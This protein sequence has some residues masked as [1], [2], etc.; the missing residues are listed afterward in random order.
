MAGPLPVVTGHTSC[1][2]NRETGPYQL[3]AKHMLAYQMDRQGP[4]LASATSVYA[5]HDHGCVRQP[6]VGLPMVVAV[7]TLQ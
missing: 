1:L 6:A 3:G 4:Q 7:T 2:R 5:I